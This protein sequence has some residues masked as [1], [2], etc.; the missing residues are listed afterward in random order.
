[1]SDELARAETVAAGLGL[2]WSLIVPHAQIMV[3][4]PDDVALGHGDV[5]PTGVA[6]PVLAEH[7]D[8]RGVNT[9]LFVA[10]QTVADVREIL[11]L[12]LQEAAA[13]ATKLDDANPVTVA[14]LRTLEAG[15]RSRVDFILAR[16][17]TVYG[18]GGRLGVDGTLPEFLPRRDGE[19]VEVIFPAFWRGPVWLKPVGPSGETERLILRW[20]DWKRRVKVS[21][22]DFVTTSKAYAAA[23]AGG[24]DPSPPLK[25][26][27]PPQWA[28]VAGTGAVPTARDINAGWYPATPGAALK[29]LSEGAATIARS[30]PMPMP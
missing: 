5:A 2:K 3:A 28:L 14:H 7:E 12:S 6:G 16:L 25:V 21:A 27:L 4:R 18:L 22:G 29:L 17:D 1:M 19:D 8:G 20:G 30:Q 23:A 24:D 26:T 9:Q 11:G 10:A 15:G 13:R